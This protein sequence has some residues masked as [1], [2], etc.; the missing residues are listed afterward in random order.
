MEAFV[1]ESIELYQTKRYSR[2]FEMA[3]NCVRK[4]SYKVYKQKDTLLVAIKGEPEVLIDRS[5]LI[6]TARGLKAFSGKEKTRLLELCNDMG[7]KKYRILAISQVY[8]DGNLA[9]QIYHRE[10][11]Q[12]DLS[13]SLNIIKNKQL[14]FQFLGLMM[15]ENPVRMTVPEAIFTCRRAGI[16]VILTTADHPQTSLAIAKTVGI[17]LSQSTINMEATNERTQMVQENQAKQLYTG[18]EL[19]RMVDSKLKTILNS[20]DDLVFARISPDEKR[21][22][23][24]CCRELNKVVTATGIGVADLGVFEQAHVSL[25][26]GRY[27]TDIAKRHSDVILLDDN[28]AT[29]VQGIREGRV[30][31]ENLKKSLCYTLSS[32][33][34]ELLP[35]I[36]FLS[37]GIPKMA[38]PI[39]ILAIDLI[40][41]NLP[42]IGNF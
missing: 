27:G 5:T 3:F 42:P 1:G 37:F 31:S 9:N 40:T 17:V 29:I 18:Q 6:M 14:E 8:L 21:R 10:N 16:K 7:R 23:V 15:L 41:D 19:T 26:M 11:G 25:S 24:V 20:T 36:F 28:F 38:G 2:Q 30:L 39:V 32:K 4:C 12:V 33:P 22:L 34:V 35:Y 13:K